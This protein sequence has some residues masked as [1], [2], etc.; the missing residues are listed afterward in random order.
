MDDGSR[1][2]C[3]LTN[4]TNIYANDTDFSLKAFTGAAEYKGLFTSFNSGGGTM[5]WTRVGATTTGT[6]TLLVGFIR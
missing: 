3:I 2:Y 5:T 1:H 6:M 4:G